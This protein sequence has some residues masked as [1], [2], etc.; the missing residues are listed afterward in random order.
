MGKFLEYKEEC[1]KAME[2]IAKDKR[3]IFIGQTVRYDGSPM[4]KSMENIPEEKRIELPVAENMQMGISIGLAI[5]GFIPVSIYP[6]IDFLICAMDQLVNHLDKIET[7]SHGEFRAG[8]IIRTQIGNTAPLNPGCQHCGDY[9]AML[10][11]GLKNIAVLKPEDPEQV[12]TAYE[13]AIQRA[14]KGKSTII[15]EIPTG[16]WVKND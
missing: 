11:M 8:V 7:M 12:R 15:V 10:R 9:T 13:I 3:T 2:H 14:K 1:K 6:R 16:G 5:E 4:F